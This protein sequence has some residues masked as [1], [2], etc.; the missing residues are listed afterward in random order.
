MWLNFINSLSM[1]MDGHWLYPSLDANKNTIYG[2]M[3]SI[4]NG[5]YLP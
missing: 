3:G 2:R 1:D 4:F 5:E